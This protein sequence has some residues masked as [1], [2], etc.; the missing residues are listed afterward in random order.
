MP[1]VHQIFEYSI[2]PK[3]NPVIMKLIHIA[4]LLLLSIPADA[5]VTKWYNYEDGMVAAG[6]M[7]KPVLLD[8]YA[9]WCSPCVAMEEGTY[10]DLRVVSEMADFV[11]IKVDTQKRIDI[12][13]KYGIAYYPTVVFLDTKGR[14]VSRHIGYLGPEEMV[15]EI[16]L[17]RGKLAK[18]SLG[19]EPLIIGMNFPG[20]LAGILADLTLIVQT[21]AFVIL[22]FGVMHAKK[23]KF[24]KHFKTADIAVISG[25]LAFLWMGSSLLN[26]SGALIAHLTSPI[27]ML[28][29]FHAAIGLMALL[30]GIAF[31]SSRFI[32][33]T[34]APM[35]IIFLFWALALFLG[36]TLYLMYYVF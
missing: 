9:D 22:L 18:E 27:T 24:S 36:I 1:P 7:E 8:F 31:V 34:L 10:P 25:V 21:A 4:I 5:G 35:R 32:K 12:E 14:E 20:T 3:A 16:K 15:E 29:I 13:S 28:A 11:A 2:Y 33:K 26:N 17:S 6:S 19:F 30:G 23:K